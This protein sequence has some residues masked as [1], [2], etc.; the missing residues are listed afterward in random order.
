MPQTTSPSCHANEVDH[1]RAD[2]Y[3]CAWCDADLCDD[4]KVDLWDPTTKACDIVC[5]DCNR[6]YWNTDR[7]IMLA[8]IGD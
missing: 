3:V 5:N 1:D 6:T 2:F 4:C 7:G 8:E